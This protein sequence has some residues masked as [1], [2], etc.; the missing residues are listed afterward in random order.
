M[1]E[2]LMQFVACYST[3]SAV[4]KLSHLCSDVDHDHRLN[5]RR[6][7]ISGSVMEPC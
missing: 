2:S 7:D 1:R 4:L 6:S 3:S 5:F